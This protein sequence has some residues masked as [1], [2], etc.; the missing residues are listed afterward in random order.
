M[1]HAVGQLNQRSL[2]GPVNIWVVQ[3]ARVA[4]LDGKVNSTDCIDRLLE[5]V[6]V[7]QRIV[8]DVDTQTIPDNLLQLTHATLGEARLVELIILTGNVGAVNF[9]VAFVVNPDP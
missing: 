6:V 7:D 4:T 5:G 3:P 8:V 9:L 1:V 2:G